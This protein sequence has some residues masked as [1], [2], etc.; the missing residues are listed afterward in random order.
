MDSSPQPGT[1]QRLCD[2]CG[3]EKQEEKDR[4]IIQTKEEISRVNSENINRNIFKPVPLNKL[5]N[6][7]Q[8]QPLVEEGSPN[9]SNKNVSGLLV[10]KKAPTALLS[11]EVLAPATPD[12]KADEYERH[13]DAV[14]NLVVQGKSAVSL[15]GEYG[16]D[17]GVDVQQKSSEI[18]QN[19]CSECEA[20][21]QPIPAQSYTIAQVNPEQLSKECQQSILEQAQKRGLVTMAAGGF[22]A[23]QAGVEL[24]KKTAI[25]GVVG[26]VIPVVGEAIGIVTLFHVIIEFFGVPEGCHGQPGFIPTPEPGPTPEPNPTRI[27][28]GESIIPAIEGFK[29]QL[30]DV[31]EVPDTAPT[32]ASERW[33]VTANRFNQQFRHLYTTAEI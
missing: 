5:P 18:V 28:I 10:T 9:L 12:I 2:E 33:E 13:A 16:G 31:T 21:E 22:V 29:N 26:T 25:R 15:L 8:N 30:P 17:D 24:T 32:D 14:A 20:T 11:G 23:T 19:K 6:T 7:R 1:I 27:G 4:E 3:A